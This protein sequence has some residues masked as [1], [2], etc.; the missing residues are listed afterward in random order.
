M[1]K[2]RTGG[3]SGGGQV[4]GR[5]AAPRTAEPLA[6]D[7]VLFKVGL[8][9]LLIYGVLQTVVWFLGYRGA[10]DPILKTTADFTG[11]CSN[12]TGVEA[13][14]TGNEVVLAT[15]VLRIDL[16]CTAISLMLVYAALVLA[17]P[18]STKSR[19]IGL[20]VG[21][22]VIAVANMLRLVAVAQLSGPLSERSFLFVHDYLFKIAMV[23]VIV[24][25][26]LAY[27][28]WARRRAA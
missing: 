22:P 1:S 27:L 8:R 25:L 14:V 24:A 2:K 23:A 20:A 6:H 18:L 12:L 19:A 21:L 28:S 4:K 11:A 10:L 5:M 15:R 9:F 13:T 17:Y 26:W 3:G 16:D 7:A